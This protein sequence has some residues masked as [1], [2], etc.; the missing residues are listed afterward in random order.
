[1]HLESRRIR[2]WPRTAFAACLLL[3]ARLTF[4][5]SPLSIALSSEASRPA[6]NDLMQAALFA[7]ATGPTLEELS[8]QV[9]RTVAGA[10]ELAKSYPEIKVQSLG[11]ATFPIHARNG[12]IESWRMR[13]DIAAESADLASLSELLG[14]LQDSLAVSSVRLLPSPETRRK[15]EDAAILEAI[16]L[17][18]ARARLVADAQ[19]KGYVIRELS[20]DTAGHF[21]PA[22]V[23]RASRSASVSAVADM[24]IESGE[25]LIRASVSG[26]IEIGQD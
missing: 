2:G 18:K 25:S 23:M 21:M 15:A 9:N 1:M 22:A 19:G 4:A 11:T 16:E 8:R 5:A 14:K 26:K 13:S 24:P 12:K 10:L 7:E 6:A 20:I 17:F 3:A